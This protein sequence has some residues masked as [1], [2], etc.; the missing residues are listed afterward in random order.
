MS[1]PIT[2]M[3]LK[4]VAM[5][6]DGP[7]LSSLYS[8]PLSVAKRFLLLLP[9]EKCTRLQKCSESRLILRDR[10]GLKWCRFV[11][12]FGVIELRHD[13]VSYVK[14]I[15]LTI[16]MLAD[17]TDCPNNMKMNLPILPGT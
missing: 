11:C 9:P 10:F 13:K 15:S 5:G 1:L 8:Q 14:M 3:D 6:V 17:A 12:S 16:L 4:S 7:S 2:G